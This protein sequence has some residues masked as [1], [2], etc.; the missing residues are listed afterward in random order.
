DEVD[1]DP[2]V[3]PERDGDL[4]LGPHRV[5]GGGE[6]AGPWQLEGPGEEAE[7]AGLLAEG[8]L[9]QRP[10]PLQR[11]LVGRDVHAGRGVGEPFLGQDVSS[12]SLSISSCWGTGTG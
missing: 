1:A 10:D 3:L 5:G 6:V 8:R 2:A 9:D 4:D 7:P 12:A 11:L